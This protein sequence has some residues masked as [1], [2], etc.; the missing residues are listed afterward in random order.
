MLWWKSEKKINF[1]YSL[2][3]TSSSLCPSIVLG[4]K[5]F[6][7]LHPWYISCREKEILGTIIQKHPEISPLSGFCPFAFS[8]IEDRKFWYQLLFFLLRILPSLILEP[9][10]RWSMPSA[11]LS[12]LSPSH[13][14]PPLL[15]PNPPYASSAYFR[16]F[17]SVSMKDLD[18]VPRSP[19]S[20][21]PFFTSRRSEMTFCAY[22]RTCLSSEWLKPPWPTL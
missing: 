6:F 9:R 17:S 20:T 14:P 11:S 15:P 4:K 8:L 18:W 13:T 3:F 7:L 10:F 16:T 21:N 5:T 1:L 12:L 19:T 2:P 22:A